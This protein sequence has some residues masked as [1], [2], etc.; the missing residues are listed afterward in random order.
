MFFVFHDYTSRLPI[1]VRLD[2]VLVFGRWTD[3]PDDGC[4]LVL[5]G[6]P[7]RLVA[8]AESFRFVAGLFKLTV[9]A[10]DMAAKRLA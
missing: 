5:R 1:R 2:E 9:S 6:E 10:D 3:E 4:G 7:V 8:V